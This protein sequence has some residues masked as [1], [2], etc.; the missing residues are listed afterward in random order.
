MPYFCRYA[1]RKYFIGGQIPWQLLFLETADLRKNDRPRNS[2]AEERLKKMLNYIHTNYSAS[3]VLRDIARSADVS[4]R[5][6]TRIF[7]KTTNHTPVEYLRHYRIQMAERYLLE[8]ADSIS[9]I[10][11]RCG[12]RDLSYFG[13]IFREETGRTP[14]QYRKDAGTRQ[15]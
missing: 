9:D 15:D 8:S 6:C 5:E 1:E 4:E 13:R 12:F 11:D 2:R 7:S 3:I 10:S 14:S